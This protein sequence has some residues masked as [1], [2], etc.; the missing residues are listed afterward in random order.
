METLDLTERALQQDEARL[1]GRRNGG[2]LIALGALAVIGS[3]WLVPQSIIAL[4][5]TS[6][7]ST[8]GTIDVA[9]GIVALVSGITLIVVGI[10][11]QRRA[12]TGDPQ[13]SAGRAN[14]RFDNPGAP[15]PNGQPPLNWTGL[16]PH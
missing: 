16:T 9:V 15:T 12:S 4:A 3:W 10:Q 7:D 14:T 2:L 5:V 13:S 1:R 8:I 11:T 6:I